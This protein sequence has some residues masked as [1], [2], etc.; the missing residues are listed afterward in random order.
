MP[1]YQGEPRPV[2]RSL[3]ALCSR[4]SIAQRPPS[5][6]AF[7]HSPTPL[8]GAKASLPSGGRLL[9]EATPPQPPSRPVTGPVP[10]SP[11]RGG[12]LFRVSELGAQVFGRQ[13]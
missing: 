13:T 6:L 8:R 10:P 9:G 12:A 2:A 4:F 7:Q 1:L 3:L 5:L 11:P